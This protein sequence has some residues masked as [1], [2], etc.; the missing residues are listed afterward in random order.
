MRDNDEEK[1]RA[2]EAEFR[3][4]EKLNHPNVIKAIELFRDNFKNEVYMVMECIE[5]EEILD[6]IA[7]M[8]DNYREYDA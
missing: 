7:K 8:E 4:L 6:H 2:H 3:I 1:L 5:G